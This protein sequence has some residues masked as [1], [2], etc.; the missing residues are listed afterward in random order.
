M[1]ERGEAGRCCSGEG[2]LRRGS[3]LECESRGGEELGDG[4]SE[5]GC[6]V[7]K[8][9]REVRSCRVLVNVDCAN[10]EVRGDIAAGVLNGDDML[11]GNV[12]VSVLVLGSFDR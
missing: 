4:A 3:D 11:G 6:S 10:L 5:R 7:V 9:K 2:T 8:E 1:P 12:G